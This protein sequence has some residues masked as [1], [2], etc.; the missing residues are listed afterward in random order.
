MEML[1]AVVALLPLVA[2]G[3]GRAQED[4]D[5]RERESLEE[6]VY[7]QIAMLPDFGQIKATLEKALAQDPSAVPGLSAL[8]SHANGYVGMAAARALGRFPS[9]SSAALLK[10]TLATEPRGLVR[11]GALT[12]LARMRDP[13][14]AN[15]A[16]AALDDANPTVVG[17]GVGALEEL[18]DSSN[19]V[20]LL[21]FYDRNREETAVLEIAGVLGDPPGS[22]AVRDKLVSEAFN[23]DNE[24]EARMAAAFG[25]RA[26]GREDLARPL[27]DFKRTRQA[28]ESLRVL[29][30]AIRTL[31]AKRN[32]GIKGQTGLDALLHDVLAT[33]ADL[34]RHHGKDEWGHSIRVRFV[35]EGQFEAISDGPDGLSGTPDDITLAEPLEVYTKRVFADLF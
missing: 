21:Q 7:P 24:I 23:K 1:L 14:T 15:L 2:G 8:I 12:G 6:V 16:K 29:E 17:A 30:G 13:E 9:P 34:A 35:G 28:Y 31:A 19:S 32:Q 4:W 10:L 11:G 18:G 26:M 20:T 25:L 5:R 3:T 33:D 22:T 27:F